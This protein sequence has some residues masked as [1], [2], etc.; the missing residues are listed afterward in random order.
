MITI[1]KAVETVLSHKP[2]LED[3]LN[4]DLINVTSLARQIQPEIETFTNKKVQQGA[5]VMAIRRRPSGQTLVME[6]KLKKIL[7]KS[8]EIIVRSKL[9]DFTY[10]NSAS[11]ILCQEKLL[12]HIAKKDDVFYTISQGVFESAFIISRSIEEAFIRL[13]KGE[14]LL[15][16]QDELSSLTIRLPSENNTV[17]GIYYYLFRAIAWEGINI[18]EVISTTNEITF[19]V[20][21]AAIGKAFS[22][23][24]GL[25]ESTK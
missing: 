3:L 18:Y 8:G 19:I 14:E 9:S 7:L 13:F 4:R 11:M 22:V 15:S 10:R 6:G 1:A 24:N 2:F 12:K 23:L 16:R 21:N 25:K 5:I 20:E 17:P